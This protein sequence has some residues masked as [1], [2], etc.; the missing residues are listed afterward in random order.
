MRVISPSVV[1]KPAVRFDQSSFTAS[2]QIMTRVFH[3]W[4]LKDA[5]GEFMTSN[6]YR[7]WLPML[8]RRRRM[9]DS[10]VDH[11]IQKP[12]TAS[13]NKRCT[14]LKIPK[15]VSPSTRMSSGCHIKI[16]R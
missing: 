11:L 13:C 12:R 1:P 4:I 16:Y 2:N 14:E 9:K 3:D 8:N 5:N 7:Q 10:A 6:R 15:R